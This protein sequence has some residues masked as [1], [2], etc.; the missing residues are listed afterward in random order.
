V[1]VDVQDR[2]HEAQIAC[3]GRL[4]REQK[5]D[6]LFD[7]D[8]PLVDLVVERDHLVGE[9]LVPLLERVDRATKGPQDER[10]FFL[11]C[12]LELVELFLERGPQ[13]NLPVT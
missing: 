11:Q 7:P 3:H 4:P 12:R 1:K 9:L 10:A 13:P 5:L 2:E 6:A 8:I